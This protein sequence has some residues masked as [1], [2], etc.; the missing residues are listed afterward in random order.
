MGVSRIVVSSNGVSSYHGRTSTLYE[1][2]G[3][4]RGAAADAQPRMS[5]DWI[6]KGLVAEAARQRTIMPSVDVNRIC[7][8]KLT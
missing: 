2:H 7:I 6:G 4:D 3:Q 8:R 5:D 1:E